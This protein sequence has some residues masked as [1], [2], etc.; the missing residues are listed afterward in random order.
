MFRRFEASLARLSPLHPH[1]LSGLKVALAWPMWVLLTDVPN[2]RARAPGLV[3]CFAAFALL[4]Y[5]DGVVARGRGLDSPLGRVLDRVTDLP[6]LLLCSSACRHELAAVPLTVKLSLDVLLLFLFAA[7]R[8]S[9]YNRVRTVASYLSLFALLALSQEWASG[10]ITRSLVTE[11]L[12]VNAGIS[13]LIVLRR[14]G[15]LRSRRV[16]DALSL[17]NLACGLLSMRFAA[18]DQLG[19][20]LL[21]LMLGAVLDGL[22]GAAARRWGGSSVGVYMDDLADAASYGFA[23]GFAL[24]ASLGG[25][26]GAVTGALFAGFVVA[27]LTFFTLDKK[28]AD[29]GLFRGVPSTIGGI[30][31]L[32]S[33]FLFRDD[34]LLVGLCVGMACALMVSFDVKHKHLGRALASQQARVWAAGYVLSLLCC[35]LSLG[36]RAGVAL[37]LM[38]A[39]SYGFFPSAKALAAKLR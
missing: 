24:Y 20:S 36:V 12:W 37:L 33:L 34:G 5:L 26:A 31:A 2:S 35:A 6:V 30:V 4:D 39:L 18:R 8:G 32:C 23:P 22:D 38:S 17:S 1:L 21:L 7:G 3:L 19:A 29:P 14:M 10:F 13:L 27:R 15:V 25:V 9:T 28:Q 11:L 16:A